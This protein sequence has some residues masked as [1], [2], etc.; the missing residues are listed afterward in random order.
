MEVAIP[1]PFPL[2][3][4]KNAALNE[5][6]NACLALHSVIAPTLNSLA[7]LSCTLRTRYQSNPLSNAALK[8]PLWYDGTLSSP[9][10]IPLILLLWQQQSEPIKNDSPTPLNLNVL[11]IL[12]PIPSCPFGAFI[13]VI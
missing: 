10:R 2:I 4:A 12:R 3:N 6:P 7:P 5:A 1:P 13:P 9:I 11:G 8:L